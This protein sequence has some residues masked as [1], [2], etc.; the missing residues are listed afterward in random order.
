[1]ID[2]I[3]KIAYFIEEYYPLIFWA[4]KDKGVFRFVM[5]HIIDYLTDENLIDYLLINEQKVIDFV[6]RYNKNVKKFVTL[7]INYIKDE[8]KRGD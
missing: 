3:N 2:K 6:E 1:M 8:I 4:L 7:A 5:R